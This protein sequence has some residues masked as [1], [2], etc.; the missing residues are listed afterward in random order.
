MP[1]LLPEYNIYLVLA[2]HNDSWP[3]V[4]SGSTPGKFSDDYDAAFCE[5]LGNVFE[6]AGEVKE[7]SNIHKRK[8][9]LQSYRTL[10]KYQRDKGDV[11]GS[12]PQ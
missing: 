11:F 6:K 7:I 5:G 3:Q 8:F 9:V 2:I 4:T 1:L 12:H 10:S